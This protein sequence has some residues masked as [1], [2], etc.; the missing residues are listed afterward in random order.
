MNARM[1]WVPLCAAALASGGMIG[2]AAAQSAFNPQISAILD[3]AFYGDSA[4]GEAFGILGE[5]AGFGGGHAHDEGHGHAHGGFE[6]GF[7]LRE[8]EIG[9]QAAV[10]PYFDAAA[11]FAIDSDGGVELEEAYATTRALP[12]G[13][14][15][16][17]GKFLSDIGYLNRQHP[18]EWHFTDRPLV[19]QLIFG[20]HGLQELG[21]QLS[22]LAPTANFLQLGLEVLQGESE[23]IANYQGGETLEGFDDERVLA[24]RSGPRM[25][26]SFARWSPDLGT[27]H[28]M[29]IGVSGGF[30]SQFHEVEEH[31][32]R[33]IDADG[34]AW[35]AGID[36][37]HKY[38]GGGFHG[39][40]NWQLQGEY[41]YRVRDFD[42]LV[43]PRTAPTHAAQ[44]LDGAYRNKQDGIYLQGVYGI[45]PRWQIGARYDGVGFTNRVGDHSP[46]TSHRYTGMLSFASTEFSRL[47]LQYAYGDILTAEVE[48]IVEIEG[49]EREDFHQVFLQFIVGL[50]AHSAHAF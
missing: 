35:F 42:L 9:L 28:T 14:Q 17:F 45:A 10:D 6:R 44:V 37:V 36:W 34:D 8:L 23:G 26:T 15:L 29:R 48:N 47:R 33:Y 31:G 50:G 21:V 13:L 18:H 7:N 12:A 32:S 16:K 11:I 20:D 46:G 5:I 19:N 3:G 49:T 30:V 22:W 38:D 27:D 25:V 24:E 41:Y 1:E 4:R 40:R 2:T 43:T 39:H